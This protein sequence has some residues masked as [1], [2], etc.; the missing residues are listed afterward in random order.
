MRTFRPGLS[1]MNAWLL[2]QGL[3]SL[4]VR[5][6]PALRERTRGSEFREDHPRVAWVN[7][8]GLPDNRYFPCAKNTFRKAP[9]PAE[10]RVEGLGRRPASASSSGAVHESP[11]HIGDAKT[12]IIHSRLDHAPADERRPTS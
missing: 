6:G 3:E 9:R 8:P 2:L 1:P 4:H 7:Y 5:I 11:R 12:L 10:L